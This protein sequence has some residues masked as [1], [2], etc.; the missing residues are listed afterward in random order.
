MM[1]RRSLLFAA[2]LFRA[3]LHTKWIRPYSTLRLMGEQA[4][5]KLPAIKVLV[6]QVRN[7]VS[8]AIILHRL[9]KQLS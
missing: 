2:P 6:E 5:T 1:T 7:Q 9:L 8:D 4:W 3:G